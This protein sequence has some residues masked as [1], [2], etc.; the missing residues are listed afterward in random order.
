M[1]YCGNNAHPCTCWTSVGCVNEECPFAIKGVIMLDYVNE[2]LPLIDDSI[3][4]NELEDKIESGWLLEFPCIV[5][6]KIFVITRGG[7][8]QIIEEHVE[9]TCFRIDDNLITGWI[10]TVD[11]KDKNNNRYAVK[12]YNKWWFSDKEAAQ[13]RL[14]ELQEGK[15]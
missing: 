15:I 14:K 10:E 11:I 7:N 6:D 8:H 3:R 9:H 12:Y 5:G 13:A 4:L 2:Y 1:I